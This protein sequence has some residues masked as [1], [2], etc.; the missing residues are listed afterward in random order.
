MHKVLGLNGINRNRFGQRDPKQYGTV[1][2]AQIN[3]KLAAEAKKLGAGLEFFQSNF[4]GE[5]VEKIHA[6]HKN[7]TDGLMVNAGAWTHYSYGLMDALAILKCPV[8][9]VH[10]SNVHAREEFRQFSVLSK[11]TV[12]CVAGFGEDSYAQALNALV[13]ILNKK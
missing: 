8:I 2:L 4:E 9:E 11:V 1:A 13:N 7:G 10:M 6:A 12:G 5:F 3:E